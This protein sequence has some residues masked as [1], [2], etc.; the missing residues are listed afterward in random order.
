MTTEPQAT[1]RMERDS[2]GEMDVPADALY[3]A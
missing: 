1:T 2:L 3:G